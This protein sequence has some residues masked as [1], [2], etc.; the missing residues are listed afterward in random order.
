[1]GSK[2]NA[3]YECRTRG[4]YLEAGIRLRDGGCFIAKSGVEAQSRV[5]LDLPGPRQA[6]PPPIPRPRPMDSWLFWLF[7]EHALGVGRGEP[8]NFGGWIVEG[9][10]WQE[11]G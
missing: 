7:M 6:A 5:H 9:S 8:A 3:S 4:H 10:E 2:G 11:L 1:M